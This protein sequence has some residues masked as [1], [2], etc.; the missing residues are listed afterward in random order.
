MPRSGTTWLSQIFASSP[1]VRL[2][3]CPLFSYEFKEL[4]N[5]NSTAE[6]WR[7][8]FASLYVTRSEFLDQDHLRRRGLIPDFLEKINPDNLIV[9]SNRFH[10][11]SRNIL[12]L[13]TDVKFIHIVR[14]PC[15]TIYSWLNDPDEF[16][17]GADLMSE[18]KTGQCRKS[19]IGEFWGFDD[20]KKV[21]QNALNLSAEFPDRHIIVKYEDLVRNTEA[22]VVE[23]FGFLNIECGESTK[24][25]IRLSKSTH[26]KH[27]HSVFKKVD[28]ND[29][30]N[31]FLPPEIINFCLA[32]ISGTELEQFIKT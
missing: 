14:H 13:N 3:S 26:D 5:E 20:W 4:L 7:A 29:K 21:T 22:K 28:L 18:W 32:D 30:W 8:L 16:P 27:K 10:N 31:D 25:F 2:K 17:S 23:L 12:L 19:N 24:K 9:K 11:L 6:E 15:A 1:D